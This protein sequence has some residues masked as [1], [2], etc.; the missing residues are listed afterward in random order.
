ML[1]AFREGGFPMIPTALIGLLL[2]A[3]SIRY[4]ITPERRYVPLQLSLGIMTLASGGLG[5]VMGVMKSV[6]YLSNV[7]ASDRWIWAVGV[8]ESL[9]NL[10]LSF[11]MITLAALAA[12]VGSARIARRTTA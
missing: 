11:A 8:G 5:F 2:V 7:P 12:S 3:A 10:A 6:Q 1:N 4:A 9:N